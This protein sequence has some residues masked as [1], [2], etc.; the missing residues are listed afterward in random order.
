MSKR[1]RFMRW[2]N[3]T[4]RNSGT[5]LPRYG[6]GERR[7]GKTREREKV[8]REEFAEALVQEQV[9]LLVGGRLLA[10]FPVRLNGLFLLLLTGCYFL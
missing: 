10:C 6:R 9:G 1:A 7:G 2:N 4:Q 3:G 5:T 8:W